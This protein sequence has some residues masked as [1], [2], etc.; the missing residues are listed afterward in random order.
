MFLM[1]EYL[2]HTYV[3]CCCLIERTRCCHVV[4][5]STALIGGL[6]ALGVVLVIGAAIVAFVVWRRQ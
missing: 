5:V 6:V 1:C 3:P 2:T 4:S